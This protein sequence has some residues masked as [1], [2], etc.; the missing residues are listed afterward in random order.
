MKN[1]R[2][3]S[4]SASCI[5]VIKN[6]RIKLMA[7]ITITGPIDE[8][9]GSLSNSLFLNNRNNK[10]L[11]NRLNRVAIVGIFNYFMDYITVLLLMTLFFAR[12]FS[13]FFVWWRIA[14]RNCAC[15]KH[16][17]LLFVYTV[18]LCIQRIT[19]LQFSF[20]LSA[21]LLLLLYIT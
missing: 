5:A 15:N 10:P 14:N 19:I 11:Q 4:V 6:H 3:Y 16:S 2:L 18:L 7:M 13:V 1:G 12:L 17:N 8:C 20:C 21:I 9:I